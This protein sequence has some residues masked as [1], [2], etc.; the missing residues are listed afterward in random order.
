M[1]DDSLELTVTICCVDPLLK[2]IG[3]DQYDGSI[4]RSKPHLLISG[5]AREALRRYKETQAD[6]TPSA[7][8]LH[9]EVGDLRL[10]DSRGPVL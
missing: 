4:V 2:S 6:G 1:P 3:P 5:I 9:S 8:D 10:P 7:L